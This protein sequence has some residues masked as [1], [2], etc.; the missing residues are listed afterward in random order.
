M[1]VNRWVAA[2]AGAAIFAT[3]AATMYLWRPHRAPA[4]ASGSAPAAAPAAGGA[5]TGL[6]EIDP[7][8]F[9]R[10]GI[11]VAPAAIASGSGS[12]RLPGTVQPNAY[13]K[14]SVTPFAGGRVTRV[15]VELGQPVQRG[16]IIAEIYS[17]EVEAARARYLAAKADT[18]AGQARLAR[19]ERLAALGS[20]SQQE[21]EEVQ[22]EHVRHETDEREAGARL[23][24]LGV[25]PA[26]VQHQ[27]AATGGATLRVAA[28]AAGVVI[29][30][31]A[32][33]GATVE[34]STILATI[35]PL[36]PVWIIADAYDRDIG[37]ISPGAEATV[38][39]EASP[40]LDAR[41][42]VAY[43]APEVRAET[44]TTQV[45]IEV[46]NPQGRLRFGMFVTVSI[47]SP[48][49]APQVRVPRSAVQTIGAAQVV[50]VAEG[51]GGRAFRAREVTLG[52]GDGDAVTIVSGLSPGESIVTQGSFTLRAEAERLGI[53]PSAPTASPGG[54]SAALPPQEA[55]VVVTEA[56]FTPNT[57][58]LEA[59]RPARVTF[60][61]RTDQTCAM[62]VHLPDYGIKRALPLNESVVVEFT[63]RKGDATF[64]CGMGMLPGR[65]IVR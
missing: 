63:P 51:S 42:R 17:P 61:R 10:A 40:G 36:S 58:A 48:A 5:A 25:D 55:T 60:T 29:E 64:Q 57:L 20:A 44:R 24:L 39:S 53:R 13:R 49:A 35:A 41:G 30:R 54:K 31:P 23:R 37:S 27:H 22:A 11:V 65:L 38:A 43:I 26:T 34:P 4:A 21:L 62:E 47:A 56:G 52:P 15:P 9:Q 50:F 14:V 33:V 6:I 18:A 8:L 59:G 3:G 2:A 32:T 12:L 7:A 28:P 16:T 46:P 19:T 1:T 45:R